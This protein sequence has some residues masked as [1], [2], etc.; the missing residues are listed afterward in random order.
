MT[1]KTHRA[2]GFTIAEIA[3]VVGVVGI[4]AAVSVLALSDAAARGKRAS[5]L[6]SVF[7]QL[8]QIRAK[9][10]ST[11][12]GQDSCLRMTPVNAT[13]FEL[14]ERA[15]CA[16]ASTPVPHD[17]R[18][19]LLV[20]GEVCIDSLARPADCTDLTRLRDFT[21]DVEIDGR[22]PCEGVIVWRSNGRL[23]ANFPVD[24]NPNA[25][26]QAHLSD[27]SSSLTPNPTAVGQFPGPTVDPRGLF[28]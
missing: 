16:A 21:I 22:A 18:A 12:G 7:S 14:D 13:T 8:E 26:V 10:L 9:H 25:D 3:V 24:D 2:R 27:A 6:K 19:T 17:F 1:L 15:D 23:T 20:S 28:E 5:S 4:V 11:A